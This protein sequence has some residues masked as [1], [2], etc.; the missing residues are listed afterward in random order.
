M[1]CRTTDDPDVCRAR[2]YGHGC[3]KDDQHEGLHH[4]SCGVKWRLDFYEY[5]MH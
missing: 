5:A 4:C 2:D 3:E 1:H